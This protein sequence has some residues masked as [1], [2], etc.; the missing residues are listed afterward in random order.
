MFI[1]KNPLQSTEMSKEWIGK[2]LI[3]KDPLKSHKL[4]NMP[5][6]VFAQKT[7]S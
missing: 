1:R 4:L 3:I 6:M 2:Y 7:Y 5:E